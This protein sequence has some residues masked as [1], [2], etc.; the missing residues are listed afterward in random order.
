MK[1]STATTLYIFFILFIILLPTICGAQST[2]TTSKTYDVSSFSQLDT[3]GLSNVTYVATNSQ[4]VLVE[5]KYSVTHAKS[6]NII[7]YVINTDSFKELALS[8][9]INDTFTLREVENKKALVVDGTDVIVN[10]E[11]IVYVPKHVKHFQ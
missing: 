2:A 7:N 10:V 3:K 6:N 9:T 4:R 11:Y 5:R 8:N 1:R